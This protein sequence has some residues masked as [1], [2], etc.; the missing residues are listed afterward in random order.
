MC[1]AALDP[2][3]PLF[4]FFP[5]SIKLDKTDAEFI[6]VIH[7]DAGGFGYSETVG[8]VDFFPNG[9]SGVQPGCHADEIHARNPNGITEQSKNILLLSINLKCIIIIK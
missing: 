1:C 9:G 5:Q 3:G 2:A 7:T 6:D 8:H 4:S